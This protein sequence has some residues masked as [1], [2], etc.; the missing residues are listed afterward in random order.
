MTD[1]VGDNLR[2]LMARR[3]VSAARLSR[4]AG[5]DQRTIRALLAGRTRPHGRTLQR[6]AEGLQVAADEFFLQPA[7]LLYRRLD[8]RSNPAVAELIS[9]R[10]ELFHGWTEGDFDE[11][12]SRVG[13]GGPLTRCGALQAV[14]QMNR[15]RRTHEQLALLLETSYAEMVRR[16]IEGLYQAATETPHEQDDSLGLASPRPPEPDPLALSDEKLPRESRR[17]GRSGAH[18][19]FRG[20]QA[21]GGSSGGPQSGQG[22]SGGFGP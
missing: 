12:F 17:S 14:E 11:L 22:Q 6:L 16:V 20:K 5:V 4:A 18:G 10:P 2:R 13:V 7:Q 3:G 8:R 15:N 21:R 19:R 1:L 9:E